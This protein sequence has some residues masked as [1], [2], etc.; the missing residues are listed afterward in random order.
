[1]RERYIQMRLEIRDWELA[2]KNCL[3]RD[4]SLFYKSL[5]SP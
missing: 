1:M 2:A 3:A 4:F 5:A